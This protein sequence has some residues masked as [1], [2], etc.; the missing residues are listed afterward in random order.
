MDQTYGVTPVVRRLQ[1]W[2]ILGHN[3]QAVG[4][5]FQV[6]RGRALKGE[7]GAYFTP[8][9]LID[10]VVSILAPDHTTSVLDPACGTGGFLASALDCVFR[11]IDNTPGLSP[12]RKANA[13][14]NWAS[15]KLF[16][17]D[18]DAVS[19]KLCKAYLTLL[20]DGRSHIY[21]ANAVDRREWAN[22]NDDLRHVVVDGRFD[23]VMTNP[24]FGKR[25]KVRAEIG[26]N[27]NRV[28]CRK[29]K[30]VDDHWE[31]TD[32]TVE[33]QLGVV[34]FERALNLLKPGGRMAIV[35]PE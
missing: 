2:R 17:V 32:E 23:L 11:A 6:F 34:F 22:R 1:Y 21:R 4:D 14:R 31:P 35:L 24:P 20:G 26:R 25:L 9:P 7:E 33:Q 5:A 12:E 10:C 28:T 13:R 3:R 19:T 15:E 16:A 18:K 30:R 8:P 27:E 29:W